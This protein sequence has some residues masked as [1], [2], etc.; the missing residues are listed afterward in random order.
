MIP[1]LFIIRFL[2]TLHWWAIVRIALEVIKFAFTQI[3][4]VSIVLF[5]SLI[6]GLNKRQIRAF[7]L[8]RVPSRWN[9]TLVDVLGQKMLKT[10]LAQHIDCRRWAQNST[11][12]KIDYW[13]LTKKVLCTVKQ[14]GQCKK[15][16]KKIKEKGLQII[17]EREWSDRSFNKG[18]LHSD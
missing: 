17:D 4:L 15:E 18:N 13:S 5:T 6:Y 16:R 12:Q 10:A 14:K 9:K 11:V 3:H 2:L 1:L 8:V 7:S